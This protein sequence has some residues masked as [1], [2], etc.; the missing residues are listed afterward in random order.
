[1]AAF[2]AL[3]ALSSGLKTIGG[4][5]WLRLPEYWIYPLQTVICGSLVFWYRREFDWSW[6]RRTWFAIGVGILV[7][8]IWISPQTWFGVVPRNNGF[9]PDHFRTAP[10]LYLG[11]VGL[12][13]ARLVLVVPL[14]EEIFWR[15]FLLRY[16][17]REPFDRVP[18]GTFTWPSFAVVTIA[19]MLS[20]SPADWPAALACGALYNCTAY[21]TKTLSACVIAHATTNL[22]LGIWIMNTRQWGFW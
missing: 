1:M 6:P 18:F 10:A 13:F 14:V 12:R 17:V 15:S 8:V 19:F 4:P 3:L 20:H 9:D 21:V 7:F 5:M 11:T 2:L 16:F 22:L